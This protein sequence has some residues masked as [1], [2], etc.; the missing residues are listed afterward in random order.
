MQLLVTADCL[1]V[2]DEQTKVSDM[3]FFVVS[4]N[5]IEIRCVWNEWCLVHYDL[6]S[7]YYRQNL[8]MVCSI[9]YVFWWLLRWKV[10]FNSIFFCYPGVTQFAM[11]VKAWNYKLQIALQNLKLTVYQQHE[12]SIESWCE[13]KWFIGFFIDIGLLLLRSF[14]R[15]VDIM[16]RQ[17]PVCLRYYFTNVKWLCFWFLLFTVIEN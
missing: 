14:L 15:N 5:S 13:I 11:R 6:T 10:S 8:R 4:I 7:Y 12:I 1:R 17:F 2:V 3:Y 9:A 16:D